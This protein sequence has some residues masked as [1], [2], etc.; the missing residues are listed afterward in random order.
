MTNPRVSGI[1]RAESGTVGETVSPSV[2][3][4]VTARLEALGGYF[5]FMAANRP[6]MPMSTRLYWNKSA[7][8]MY[9]GIPSLP[10]GKKKDPSLPKVRGTTACRARQCHKAIVSGMTRLVKAGYPLFRSEAPL[11]RFP[12]FCPYQ[13]S[14]G[15]SSSSSSRSS[16]CVTPISPGFINDRKSQNG[17]SG[18]AVP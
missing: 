15:Y 12:L 9:M 2:A 5:F 8:V 17:A 18:F 16:S 11:Y 4:E 1:V 14:G 13:E 10:G 6:I 3:I 7:S